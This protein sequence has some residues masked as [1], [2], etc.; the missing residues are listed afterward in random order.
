MVPNRRIGGAGTSTIWSSGPCKLGES[1]QSRELKCSSYVFELITP[2]IGCPFSADRGLVPNSRIGG[3]GSSTRSIICTDEDVNPLRGV[4]RHEVLFCRQVATVDKGV[5]KLQACEHLLG[6]V[7][8]KR[9]GGSGMLTPLKACNKSCQSFDQ[10]GARP[11]NKTG[12]SCMSGVVYVLGSLVILVLLTNGGDSSCPQPERPCSGVR[13]AGGQERHK[14]RKR[15]SRDLQGPDRLW[16]CVSVIAVGASVSFCQV[17]GATD[18]WFAYQA[19]SIGLLGFWVILSSVACVLLQA[20]VG[21]KV[22][23]EYAGSTPRGDMTTNVVRGFGNSFSV[24]GRFEK[25][26]PRPAF[27]SIGPVARAWRLLLILLGFSYAPQVFAMQDAPAVR[28]PLAVISLFL[29]DAVQA[30]TAPERLGAPPRVNPLRPH[31]QPVE[32]LADHL[33]P[34]LRWPIPWHLI[35]AD[36]R[37]PRVS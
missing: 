35:P 14:N 3:A 33:G 17:A 12:A 4:C 26:K 6:D 11:V 5:C 7:P 32:Q 36:P 1:R 22:C 8:K 24:Q 21:R 27:H 19:A 28:C 25:P 37:Q 10:Y 29:P 2:H 23:R 34:A 18:A 9:I 31:E 20:I 13:V 30:M 16:P 15:Q